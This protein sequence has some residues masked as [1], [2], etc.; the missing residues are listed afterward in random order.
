MFQKLSDIFG[1]LSKEGKVQ[2]RDV[3][4]SRSVLTA[5]GCGI[6]HG[7][8]GPRKGA[9]GPGLG[10]GRP[11]FESWLSRLLHGFC[12]PAS[13]LIRKVGKVMT[14]VPTAQR[15]YEGSTR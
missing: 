3:S 14:S 12:D 1:S 15:S 7:C 9:E 2:S 4:E 13:F 5:A 8:S 6:K 10:S 11:G